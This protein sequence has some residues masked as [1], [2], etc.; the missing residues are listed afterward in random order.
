[1]NSFNKDIK[2]TVQLTKTDKIQGILEFI[3]KESIHT[4]LL[5]YPR[6]TNQDTQQQ[7]KSFH[8]LPLKSSL[9]F[10]SFHSEGNHLS[11]FSSRPQFVLDILTLVQWLLLLANP[12]HMRITHYLHALCRSD[13][14]YFCCCQLMGPRGTTITCHNS[15]APRGEFFWSDMS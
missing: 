1:M 7:V 12:Q 3:Y 15:S 14:C 10:D 9:A 6:T 8:L 4:Y 11:Y 2:I 13:L 5:Q